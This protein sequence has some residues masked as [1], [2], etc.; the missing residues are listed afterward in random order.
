MRI[1]IPKEVLPGETRVALTPSLVP[2][3][4]RE[5]HEVLVESGAGTAASFSDEQYRQAGACLVENVTELYAGADIVFKV[6]PPAL[7]PT[8]G[9]HEAVMVREGASYI[10]FL[11]PFNNPDVVDLFAQRRIAG[12]AMEF[13]PRLARTQNM[14]ALSSMATVAGYKAVLLAAERLGQLFPLMMTA[15]GT[16]SP[17]NVLVLGA[18]VAGLQSIAMSKRMGAK[19]EAFDPRPAVKEQIKSLGAVFVEM[20]LTEN[21]ETAG[22]YAKEQSDEFLRKEQEAISARLSKMDVVISTAQ[23]FG[24]RAPVL[25]TAEMV[26]LL[27][28][29]AVIVDLAAEQGGNCALTQAGQTIEHKGVSIIGAMNLPATVPVDAS[30]LYARNVLNLF[31]YLYP[32]TA[33]APDL[34]DEVVKGTCITHAGEVVHETLKG[35]KPQGALV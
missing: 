3:L 15:A 13:I 26:E 31:R 23:I 16:I 28:P 18:G 4:M 11:A 33:E 5:K 8:T 32:A 35:A 12:Y 2:L 19:V 27:K 24:K 7:H 30:Q 6:Q 17:V 34:L 9:Q 10:G 1:G 29:G 21:V 14:D 22:G 20:E 25:I